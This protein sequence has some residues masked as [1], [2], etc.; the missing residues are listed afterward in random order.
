[1]A[2]RFIA[3]EA[4]VAGGVDLRVLRQVL[5]RVD[6]GAVW[7]RVAPSWFRALWGQRIAAVCMAWGVYVRPDV[8]DRHRAGTDPVRTAHLM[9][10]ELTHLEQWRRLG[11]VRHTMRYA[12]DYLRSRFAGKAHRAAYRAVRLEVEARH[13]ALLVA[14]I[15][16]TA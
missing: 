10:H 13:A 8:M 6:P 9:V 1:M 14:A 3:E 2:E 12:G 7:V 5:P 16:R 4:L 15:G 11:G